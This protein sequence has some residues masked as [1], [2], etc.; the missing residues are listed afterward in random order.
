M[1]ID[2]YYV[3]STDGVSAAQI[4]GECV[5]EHGL[6]DDRLVDPKLLA[7]VPLGCAIH[8]Y[9]GSPAEFVKKGI[10]RP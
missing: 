8:F 4:C 2:N 1:M 6:P 10:P 3:D 9:G 7:L 5:R